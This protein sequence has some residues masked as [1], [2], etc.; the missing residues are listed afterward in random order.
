MDPSGSTQ[1][2]FAA[3]VAPSDV[4]ITGAAWESAHGGGNLRYETD[5]QRA[6]DGFAWLRWYPYR[7]CHSEAG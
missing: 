2:A 5:R 3:V 4:V 7:L 6:D 1:E